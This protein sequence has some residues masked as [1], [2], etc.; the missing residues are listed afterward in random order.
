MQDRTVA[1]RARYHFELARLYAKIGK[2]DMAIQYLR[3]SFEEGFRRQRQSTEVPRVC[4]YAGESGFY[5]AD[6]AGAACP[7]AIPPPVSFLLLRSIALPAY[8]REDHGARRCYY[9]SFSPL[10]ARNIR[11]RPRTMR[12]YRLK[13]SRAIHR[14][15]GQVRAPANTSRVPLAGAMGANSSGDVLSP[16]ALTRAN[17][18]LGGHLRQVPPEYRRARTD[19]IVAGA[20][21]IVTG[22][23]ERTA[24]GVRITA[25]EED[26]TTRKTTRALSAG[27]ATPFEALNLL[28][29][30]FSA[31]A[32]S[33]RHEQCRGL[34]PLLHGIDQ[35][36]GCHC[37]AGA[38]RGSRSRLRPRACRVTLARISAG[39][40]RA[41]G[42]IE[43]ARAQKIAPMDRAWLDYEDVA[44]NGD[45]TA[46]LEALRKVAESDASDM[47]LA[48]SLAGG[49]NSAPEISA[50]PPPSGES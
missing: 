39:L 21:H 6:G 31:Q 26:V 8:C 41:P 5:R 34:P 2:D 11:V 28:A 33:S 29:H 9:P 14:S 45:R 30:G 49:R 32:G 42:V 22:Y 17:Q 47:G 13:T 23:I 50:R 38:C 48:R 40:G 3:H 16:D 36:A 4:R 46:R 15:I 24:S 7:L 25:S 44:L 20:N 35:R 37:A 10:V 12:S 18:P 43:R 1:D 27:A 19:A